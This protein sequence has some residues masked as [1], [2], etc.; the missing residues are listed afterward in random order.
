[1]KA[2]KQR[3]KED[4]DLKVRMLKELEERDKVNQ[5]VN[6]I[7]NVEIIFEYKKDELR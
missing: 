4:Y 3:E 7:L 5:M 6:K 2:I 1:M